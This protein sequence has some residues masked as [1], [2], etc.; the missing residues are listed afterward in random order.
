MANTGSLTAEQSLAG[1]LSGEQGLA[2]QLSGDNGLTGG[3]A[4]LKIYSVYTGVTEVTPSASTQ[5]LSTAGL[6]VQSDITVNPI[7]SNYGLI[8]WNG[9]FLTV[10]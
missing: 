5:T 8:T 2:G 3:L 4:P 6:V 7:P 9:S 1:V 10:S